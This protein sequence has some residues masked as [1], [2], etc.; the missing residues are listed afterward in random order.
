MK[1]GIA[2]FIGLLGIYL[3]VISWADAPLL[4]CAIV[5][6]TIYLLGDD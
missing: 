5:W 6:G 3:A 2:L 1:G 4:S